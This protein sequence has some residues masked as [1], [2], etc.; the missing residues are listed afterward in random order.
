MAVGGSCYG[1]LD[2]SSLGRTA[3]VVPQ[4]RDED[5]DGSERDDRLDEPR[6]DGHSRWTAVQL[7]QQE[8]EHAAR[9]T[10]K[11]SCRARGKA[12]AG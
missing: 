7:L 5:D 6:R 1:Q 9:I 10:I 12:S 2:R 4:E 11:A 8:H 3:V